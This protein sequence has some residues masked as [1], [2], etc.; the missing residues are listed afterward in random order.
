M[1]TATIG[2]AVMLVALAAT[3]ALLAVSTASGSSESRSPAEIYAALAKG[4]V[5]KPLPAT[6]K[7]SPKPKKVA[8]SAGSKKQHAV[9]AVEYGNPDV[10]VGF[11]VFPSHAAALADLKAYPPN[12]GPN[13]IVSRTPSGL[14]QPALLLLAHGNGYE[15]AYATFVVDDVLVDCWTY[16]KVAQTK[17]IESI[18]QANAHWALKYSLRAIRG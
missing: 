10:V 14:P 3:A 12:R 13:K 6:L 16:G 15:A 1:R 7:A 9:G 8:L 2:H 17:V 5:L 4:P 18:V 11:L